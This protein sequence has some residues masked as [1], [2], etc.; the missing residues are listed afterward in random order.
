[1]ERSTEHRHGSDH[2]P[3]S[4]ARSQGASDHTGHDKH[5][6][7]SVE[8]FRTRFWVCLALTVPALV[9]EPMLQD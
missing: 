1:M 7:H 2:R 5:A 6:G 4:S 9:W 3:A 8:M